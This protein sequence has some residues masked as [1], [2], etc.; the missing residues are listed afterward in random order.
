MH[1]YYEHVYYTY[2]QMSM[3][4]SLHVC[5]YAD[6]HVYYTYMCARLDPFIQYGS[7]KST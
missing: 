3:S 6:E 2:M 1:V 4:I 5:I 7:T